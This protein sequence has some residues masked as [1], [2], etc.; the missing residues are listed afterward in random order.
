MDLRTKFIKLYCTVHTLDLV[1]RQFSSVHSL[2]NVKTNLFSH[3]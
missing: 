2:K 1:T 3:N